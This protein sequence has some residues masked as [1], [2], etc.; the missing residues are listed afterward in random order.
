MEPVRISIPNQ[1]IENV[2]DVLDRPIMRRKGIEKE[3]VPE[4]LQDKE[5]ALDERIV[6]RQVLIVPDELPLEGREMHRK[7][8][9]RENNAAHPGA[10]EQRS[11]FPEQRLISSAGCGR[12]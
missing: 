2:G 1:V 11:C 12:R 4:T 3:I 9:Q 5:R 6:A 10:L 8:K 7:P